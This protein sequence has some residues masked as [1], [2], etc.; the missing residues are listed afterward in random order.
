MKILAM[1]VAATWT[2]VTAF[3]AVQKAAFVG[4]SSKNEIR[5]L[6]A[7]AGKENPKVLV[8]GSAFNDIPRVIDPLVKAFSEFTPTNNIEA[9]RLAKTPKAADLPAVRQ[10]ILDA[11]I[12]FFN[13]GATEQLA[14]AIL[15]A[16]VGDT[17]RLAYRRGTLLCGYS[18]GAII[19]SHAGLTDYPAGRYD[20]VEGLGVVDAYMCPHYE[21][22]SE[23]TWKGFDKRLEAETDA[24]LPS[25]AWA[26]EDGTMVLFT[27]G[28][29]AVKKTNPKRNVWRF[30]RTDGVWKKEAVEAK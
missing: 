18:A 13:G 4:G 5:E 26:V 2:A 14:K 7:F 16:H 15:F 27:D 30:V 23:K 11:D 8:C 29:P 6:C 25:E 20:L 10:K 22:G 1:T 9:L 21:G 24:S 12:I 28:K 19:L 3:G 17:L